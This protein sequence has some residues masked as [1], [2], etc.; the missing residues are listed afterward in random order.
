MAQTLGLDLG[1]NSIG[2]ALID[3]DA[4]DRPVRVEA[5]G[6]RI[7]QE[8][9]DAV[10]GKPKNQARRAARMA[11]RLVSRRRR[12]REK[13]LRLLLSN[14]L[15]PPDWLDR[16][17]AESH[18]NALGNPYELRRKGLDQPLIPYEFGRVFIH[19]CHR[20]GFE[21]NR[22]SKP[23]EEGE[24]KQAISQLQQ[25]IQNAGCRTLG[26]FL[27]GQQKKRER[28]T[29]RE[30][31]RQEFEL[32]WESQSRFH[33]TILT[34][35][36]KV[37]V[38]NIIFHQRPLK[39]K[40]GSVGRCTF[41]PRRF[42]ASRAWPDAQRF[43]LLQ[44]LNHLQIKSP[45]TRE[46]RHLSSGERDKL[47]RLLEQQ[48]TVSWKK[49]RRTLGLHEGELFN[50]EEG[51]KEELLGDQT[52]YALRKVLGE[53]WNEL[54]KEQR[55]LL[56]CDLLTIENEAGLLNR[57]HT[58]W[59]L[60]KELAENL[61]QIELEDGYFRLSLKA[62]RKVL[63]HLEQ[64]LTYDKACAAAGYVHTGS[65]G[66][67]GAAKLGNP[68]QLRNPVVQ[69]ALYEARKV[70]NTVIRQYG[71]PSVIRVEMARDMKLSK[72]QK[73]ALAKQAKQNESLNKQAEEALR[74]RGI[75]QP[76]RD[77]KVKYRLWKE[78]GG[79]CLYTGQPIGE[80]ML[81][82]QDVDIEHIL[83]YSRTL[84][85]SYMNKT[86]CL[87]RENRTIKHNRSPYEAYSSSPEKYADILQRIRALPCFPW[88]KR[89][90]F[91]QKEIDTE[92]FIT[93]QLNDTRYICREVKDYLATLGVTVEVSK[94]EATAWL[95]HTW[96][97]NR[98]LAGD[99]AIEKNR[100]DH[101]H[102]A[103][104]AVVIALTSRRLFQHLS[105]L[106]A[107]QHGPASLRRLP[108][109]EPWPDFYPTVNDKIQSIVVSHAPVHKIRDAFHEDT[110]YGYNAA[111]RSFVYRVPLDSGFKETAIPQIRDAAVRELVTA[112]LDETGGDIKRAFGDPTN[113]LRHVDG[114]TPIRSVRIKARVSRETVA[115]VRDRNGAEYK[116]FKY[117]NNHHVEIIEH[118]ATGKRQGIF[119]TTMEAARRARI[120]K[121][122]IVQR[123]PPWADGGKTYGEGWS[124]VMS[125]YINDLAK[126]ENPGG[127]KLMRVQKLDGS[128]GRVYFRDHA[129]ARTERDSEYQ[130]SVLSLR[131]SKIQVNA[132]GD[133]SPAHD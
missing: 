27:A 80:A 34:R 92:G 33:P 77:D 103:V 18:Y 69:K 120:A 55:D 131:C 123:Q 96:G 83:P 114:V 46:Y 61:A 56:V 66:G 15:L 6:V 16:T 65:G 28:H 81:F 79:V 125:L 91:E 99:G 113:P 30:M 3:H 14:G 2:W 118:Q 10:R 67:T 93:R 60:E 64:G 50:L 74:A 101:R 57:L 130:K 9:V 23:K 117:G 102:H 8:A 85:D 21:S 86:L 75:Q 126:I 24:I 58:W 45:T 78:A 12:R 32:L 13:L 41:E 59:G 43:R 132:L 95:R 133:V 122:P 71:K 40:S 90:R 98:I 104:D 19:L 62:I 82:S 63:P 7:F 121:L 5:C 51:K 105:K 68:P 112:R 119:V 38:H 4:E 49:A 26:E 20:R 39:V 1:T 94:G 31:Y 72:A 115:P 127:V 97:L 52:S 22:K 129:D 128:N 107:Q 84:D 54:S 88:S 73:I 70:V 109:G 48:K 44:D 108:I 116:F 35:D 87:A 53:K 110:A 42:R 100:N 47:L 76:S 37:V 29:G 111:T 17:S 124:F 89:R 36:F 25:A 11:R 106:S